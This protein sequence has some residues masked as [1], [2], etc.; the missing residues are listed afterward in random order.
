MQLGNATNPQF[1][2]HIQV[3][4]PELAHAGADEGAANEALILTQALRTAQNTP[5]VRMEKVL[6][7]KA[8][9][10]AGTYVI[11]AASIARVLVREEPGLFM[12]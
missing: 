2:R 6:A 11:D 12:R 9:I 1:T 10:E 4:E 5:D 3:L 8:S 7:I